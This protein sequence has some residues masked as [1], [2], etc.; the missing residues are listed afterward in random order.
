MEADFGFERFAMAFE[1]DDDDEMEWKKEEDQEEGNEHDETEW[2]AW[3]EEEEEDQEEGNEYDGTEEGRGRKRKEE[4]ARTGI[5]SYPALY[6]VK[7]GE[8]YEIPR[9]TTTTTTTTTRGAHP[10]EDVELDDDN[11]A[12]YEELNIDDYLREMMKR[13]RKRLKNQ[14]RRRRMKR[15][16]GSPADMRYMRTQ[17]SEY[18]LTTVLRW[19]AKTMREGKR[20][21]RYCASEKWFHLG[22]A[23]V[24]YKSMDEFFRVQID[25]AFV[26]ANATIR[27]GLK[28]ASKKASTSTK[29]K[30][31][32]K[33]IDKCNDFCQVWL[34]PAEISSSS[35]RNGSTNCNKEDDWRISGTSV[36][37]QSVKN[38]F[39]REN[40][41][42]LGIENPRG[43]F[44][45]LGIVVNPT[46][47]NNKSDKRNKNKSDE[48]NK[49]KSD[50][51]VCVR[52]NATQIGN[53]EGDVIVTCLGSVLIQ[54]RIV[55]VAFAQPRISFEAQILG[56]ESATYTRF[57]DSD[58]D[59]NQDDNET[60]GEKEEMN[61]G[62]NESQRFALQSFMNEDDDEC[63]RYRLKMVQGPPGTG[64]T[65]FC[66]KLLHELYANENQQQRLLVCAPS[67][68]AVIVCLE[69]FL[70][71]IPRGKDRE[72]IGKRIALNGVED[73]LESA[74]TDM[75]IMNEFYIYRQL[76]SLCVKLKEMSRP[77]NNGGKRS[78]ADI[79][80]DLK[81]R[82]QE[83]NRI[84]KFLLSLDEPIVSELLLSPCDLKNVSEGMD[85]ESMEE[86][87]IERIEGKD[88]HEYCRNRDVLANALLRNA[89][90][91]FC[92]LG[93]CSNLF[94][95]GAEKWDVL[96]VDEAANCL[97]GEILLAFDM[98][99]NR[100]LLIGDPQQLPA[101][102]NSQ[103]VKRLG[104]DKSLMERLFAC[105]YYKCKDM[106]TMLK[107]QY[108]MH[109]EICAWP[110]ER[111]Y[112]GKL[113][114]AECVFL[115]KND[116][117]YS[118]VN[119]HSGEQFFSS[120]FSS[121]N[122]REAVMAVE[123]V[124]KLRR[125]AWLKG[126]KDVKIRIITFYTAQVNLITNLLLTRN[127][128]AED[129]FVSTVDSFQGSEADVI[130]LSCVRTSKTSV[131]FLSDSRRLNVSLT[132]A[133]KKLIVLCK[134]DALAWGEA[135]EMLDLKSL[136]E[137]AKSR[138][139]LFSESEPNLLE[140]L[141]D[142]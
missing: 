112:G 75:N 92:T 45:A 107:T 91:C 123:L 88:K 26:E 140:K 11:D 108:R 1:D 55:A 89:R 52:T 120:N 58:E 117:P 84:A 20:G 66:A 59:E 83:M 70:R 127:V 22:E 95:A 115:D 125:K 128:P 37:L 129:V 56:T 97:E 27:E 82:R 131:G 33:S 134:A 116:V 67:N 86:E 135:L 71:N 110:S 111:F 101:F 43:N 54:K 15:T 100:C 137:N 80:E 46:R 57:S 4:E 138:N 133:K 79:L 62:L 49:N 18:F 77:S 50:K 47:I 93:S 39:L 63:P 44:E 25:V 72:T 141:S 106:C 64:K 99:P 73:T 60:N 17:G 6:K 113:E 142:L 109:P 78:T 30:C 23:P 87:F 104:Y 19:D 3:A 14:E 13:E 114:N 105:G 16:H 124:Q 28:E 42:A 34:K 53:L 9:T 69:T 130:I 81:N 74:A 90:L 96:I 5:R 122:T 38:L 32:V 119:V 10:R 121:S 65:H 21:S 40:S 126:L 102:C 118:I 68:K 29:E 36:L 103:D 24:R 2:A 12:G 94:H 136:I 61:N 7:N 139:M 48:R 132:R 31:V 8:V 41:E 76:D 98:N 51:L 35:R 85:V